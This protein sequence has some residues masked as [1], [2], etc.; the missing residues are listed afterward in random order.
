MT[1]K[2]RIKI[3]RVLLKIK[4]S[5][6]YFRSFIVRKIGI[7]IPFNKLSTA[8]RIL[9]ISESNPISKNQIF[10]FFFYNQALS[11]K[12]IALRELP[13][14]RFKS[15][16]HSYNDQ[17][18]IVFL[19]T[20][21]DYTS[22]EMNKLVLSIKQKWPQAKLVYADWFAHTDLRYAKVLDRSIVAYYK[23]TIIKDFN[24]YYKPTNKHTFI[25]NYYSRLLNLPDEVGYFEVPD[26]FQK[27]IFVG[28]SFAFADYIMIRFFQPF[29]DHKNRSIDIHLRIAVSGSPWYQEMR[30]QCFYRVKNCNSRNI[31]VSEDR[32]SRNSFINE[33]L[34][35]KICFS[36]FGYGEVCWR[37]FEAICTGSLLFK[38]D[39]SHTISNPD[40]FIPYVTYIPLAWDLSDFDEKLDYYL[41][42]PTERIKIT[43][44]AFERV[45]NYF[46]NNEFLTDVRPLLERLNL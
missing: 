37:D 17:I 40:I 33:L 27:N 25:S 30:Q 18:D 31:L 28:S 11:K 20:W 23:K 36:P 12:A 14:E 42:N 3:Y 32:I 9:F 43:R 7:L 45:R 26:N 21:F 34:N 38:Q 6:L 2:F 41:N 1:E 22:D 4:L 46:I 39:M 44:N 13:I 15:N 19:Q 10:P 35:S 29:P 24:Q 16:K 5:K 8:K